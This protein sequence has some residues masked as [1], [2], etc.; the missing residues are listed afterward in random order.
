MNCKRCGALIVQDSSFCE[1]CG[2]PVDPDWATADEPRASAGDSVPP[3]RSGTFTAAAGSSTAT[4][5]PLGVLPG[6]PVRLANG[7]RLCQTYEAVRLRNRRKG[8]GTLYVTDARVVFY[9]WALGRGIQ[10]RSELVQEVS[11]QDIRGLSSYVTRQLRTLLVILAFWFALATL[12]TL[13]ALALPLTLLFAILTA[14][15]I[16][17]LFTPFGQ[18]GTAGVTLHT[19]FVSEGAVKFGGAPAGTS[20][21]VAL[22]LSPL[23]LIVHVFLHSY[24]AWDVSFGRPGNDSEKIIAEL[25][26]L[27]MD[28]NTRGKFAGENYGMSGV[29]GPAQDRS[30]G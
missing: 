25:G 22:L 23:L 18:R 21:L 28:L 29:G 7:E 11:L 20:G 5:Q 10:Q 17:L 3:P 1:G 4:A 14:G 2:S 9:A 16:A 6:S 8:T 12:A 19:R 26:A 24:T 27:I 30:A 15:C 13:A